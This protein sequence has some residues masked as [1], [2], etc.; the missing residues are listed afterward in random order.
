MFFDPFVTKIV[1]GFGEWK[2]KFD[3]IKYMATFEKVLQ[4]WYVRDA[5]SFPHLFCHSIYKEAFSELS[6]YFRSYNATNT[7]Q[8]YWL[9]IKMENSCFFP[10]TYWVFKYVSTFTSKRYY[11]LTKI[12]T[13]FE[14]TKK[15]KKESNIKDF[16]KNLL[17]WTTEVDAG[18]KCVYF[19]VYWAEFCEMKV[20]LINSIFCE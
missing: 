19:I 15:Q 2:F 12:H 11:V 3:L 10:I 7:F 17:S 13:Y 14:F 1:A 6:N 20:K 9:K 5:L 18:D 16:K 4:I 8:F